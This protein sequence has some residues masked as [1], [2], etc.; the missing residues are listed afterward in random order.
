[1]LVLTLVRMMMLVVML[2]CVLEGEMP[3]VVDRLDGWRVKDSPGF[4]ESS[5]R[6]PKQFPVFIYF[7][8]NVF[9]VSL[10]KTSGESD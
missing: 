3:W 5:R 7:S 2:V 10:K 9:L 6:T 8:C 1:M 4:V